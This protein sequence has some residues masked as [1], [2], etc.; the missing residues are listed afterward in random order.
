M[1]HNAFT[2]DKQGTVEYYLA[3]SDKSGRFNQFANKILE[4]QGG[5]LVISAT[6]TINS[7]LAMRQ[8]IEGELHT[9]ANQELG[10]L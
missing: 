3:N 5:C 6:I 8:V 10:L 1:T 7:L 4:S 2:S 9:R